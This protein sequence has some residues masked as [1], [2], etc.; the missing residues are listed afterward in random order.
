MYACGIYSFS[1][2]SIPDYIDTVAIPL[3]IDESS[4]GPPTMDQDLTDFLFAR[5]VE[6]TR[7]RF[8]D[9]ENAAD[10]VLLTTIERYSNRPTAVTG[11]EV[12]A[13][14]SVT[15]SVRA[16][17]TDRVEDVE[18][19]ARSFSFD[20]EY[21]PAEGLEGETDAALTALEEIAE[22]IFTAAASDW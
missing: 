22:Q 19:L 4:G 13:L 9:D 17:Y 21:D 5:F 14:N 1:G 7:L 6:Q 2:A 18:Q 16:V 3:A 12:A 20:V 8:L 15:I 10:A 11:N